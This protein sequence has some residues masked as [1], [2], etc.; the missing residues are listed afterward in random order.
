MPGALFNRTNREVP[1]FI[2]KE[3]KKSFEEAA[4]LKNTGAFETP[5]SS[6]QYKILT[7][8]NFC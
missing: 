2:K 4:T 8:P 3:R 1:R 6:C 7:G 5:A